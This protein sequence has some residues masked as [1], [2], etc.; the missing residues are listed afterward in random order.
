MKKKQNGLFSSTLTY[1]IIFVLLVTG[2]AYYMR[3]NG[4]TSSQEIETST[5]MSELKK[6]NVKSY[7]LQPSGGVYKVSGE[8][9]KAEKSSGTNNSLSFFGNQSTKVTKFSTYIPTNDATLSQIQKM[10]NANNVKTNTQ[11]ESQSGVWFS[12]LIT[13]VPIVIMMIFFYMMMNQA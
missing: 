10:T 6:D 7:S 3:D 1:I 12:L 11:E 4:T 9:K 5:F 8:Y 2:F 13:V